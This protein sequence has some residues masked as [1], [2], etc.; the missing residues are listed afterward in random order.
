MVRKLAAVFLLSLLIV[1]FVAT[2]VALGADKPFKPLKDRASIPARLAPV[3]SFPGVTGSEYTAPPAPP[4]KAVLRGIKAGEGILET[5]GQTTYDYQHNCTMGRQVEHRR[6]YSDPYDQYGFYVHFDWMAQ[7]GDTL[8]VNRGIGFQSYE[9]AACGQKFAAG[10]IRIEG[11]YAGY[12]NLD[13][14]NIDALTSAAVPMAHQNEDTYYAKAFFDFGGIGLFTSDANLTD[15]FGWWQN[16]GTGPGNENIWPKGDWD[17]D[18][19]EQVLHL[20]TCESGGAAG[21]PQTY[22]YYRRVGGYGTGVGTWSDQRIIDTGMN[23][24]VTVASSPVSDKVAVIWNAP[25]DYWRAQGPVLEFNNQMEND[26]WFAIA[27]DN[28]AAWA[29]V[30]PGPPSIGQTVDLG[31]GGGYIAA[32]GGNLTTYDPMSDWKAYCDMSAL[33]YID[34]SENDWL[35][36]VWGCRRWT[37]TTSVYRRQTSIFHWNQKT[38]VIRTVVKADWDTGGACYIPT[39]GSDAAKMTISQCDGRLYVSYTQFGSRDYP[40][41]WYDADNNVINGYLYMSVFDPSY[42]AWDRAQRVTSITESATNCTPGDMSGPGDCNSEYWASMARYGRYDTCKVTTPGEVL[43]ILY[44]HDYAPGGCVQT[45]SGVWTLNPVNWAVYPCREAVPEP[46]Y[47]DDAGAGYGLCVSAPILVIGTT[48]DTTFTL[49]L[50]NFGILDNTFTIAAVITGSNGPSN[51]ANTTIGLD[52][53]GGNILGK[54]GLVPV[55]VTI[56][57]VGEDDFSTVQGTITVTHQAEGSPR[58]IPVC[59]TVIDGWN[60]IESATLATACKRLRVYNNGQMSNNGS[61]MSLDYINPPDSDNCAFVYLY[62]A[63]PVICRDVDGTKYCY[64]SVYDNDYASDHA[65]RQVSAM[66]YD[67]VSNPDYEYATAEFITGDSAI[68]LIV[69]YFAPKAMGDCEFIVQ[70]L[71]FWNRTGETLFG[72]AVGE[73]LDWDVPSFE[74][75]SNNESDY[76]ATRKLIYQY[77]GCPSY[78]DQCDTT[79]Q[80]NRFAG[81]A[82]YGGH[83]DFKNYMTLQNATYVYTSGPY[84]NEAPLPDGPTYDL[85]TG[86]EGFVAASLDSCED[87]FTLVTFD[88]YDLAPNDTMCVVKILVTSRDDNNAADLKAAVDAANTFIDGHDEIKCATAPDDPCLDPLTACRPGDANGD[89]QVNVGDAVYVIG[90]VFKGGPAPTP[91]PKCSG[92]AQGDC[93]C[94]VGD[95]VYII[96]YVFKGGPAPVSCDTWHTTCG[97]LQ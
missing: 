91:F 33:W 12:V 36:I 43:D 73:A 95:A 19:A 13:A 26:V 46:G 4:E 45:N 71:K 67:N 68:S 7:S 89:G 57:T 21:D 27:T 28:G 92:D 86:T 62:D 59:I 2:S 6:D 81:I 77:C 42:D 53:A 8:G 23:I 34:G 83:D 58:T 20:A 54:G 16:D 61:N 48:D 76:D 90:Y 32:V 75:G 29:A 88:V 24:N 14:N 39:W 72:T 55:Q 70:K 96:A 87:L 97:D 3:Y 50:E 85:M 25:A 69:E 5:I 64:F 56:T 41:D 60:A 10:G 30:N 80:C 52:L 1:A 79:T 84:G 31:I 51:G 37:D 82:S 44:I 35:Q 65:L 38:D 63:S 9:I 94:N 22:S 93:Q 66:F 11:A 74:H 15:N 18:G 47:S 49:T 40:C 17:I 78:R